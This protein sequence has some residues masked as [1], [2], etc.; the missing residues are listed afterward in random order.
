M[1]GEGLFIFDAKRLN[2]HIV[3]FHGKGTT[4][5]PDAFQFNVE[6]NDPWLNMRFPS[7]ELNNNYAIVDN[8]GGQQPVAGEEAG[9]PVLRDGVTD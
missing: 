3:R 9:K 1:W 8:N 7:T 5:F 6:N 2:K 4:N